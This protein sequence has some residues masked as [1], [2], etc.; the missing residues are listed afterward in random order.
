M[1]MID[2]VFIIMIGGGNNDK[3]SDKEDHD[4]VFFGSSHCPNI[5]SWRSVS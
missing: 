3:E 5:V 4:G 1:N 2:Y